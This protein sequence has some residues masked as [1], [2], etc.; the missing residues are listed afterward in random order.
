MGAMI[1][2]LPKDALHAP[3]MPTKLLKLAE[4]RW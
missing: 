3:P 2:S 1:A 4:V